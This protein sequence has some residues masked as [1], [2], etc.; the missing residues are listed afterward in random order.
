[1]FLTLCGV[2]ALLSCVRYVEYI[3]DPEK[4]IEIWVQNLSRQRSFKYLYE[5]KTQAVFTAA[6]GVC[7]IGRGEHVEG[8]WYSPDSQVP[9]EYYGFNDVE[10][11]KEQ[12]M[13]QTMSRGDE[14]DILAQVTR[15]LEFRTFEYLGID[16]TYNYTFKANI[17]F[18][19]PGRWKEMVG[20]MKVSQRSYLPTMIWAG[21]PDSSVYWRI[22]LFE[23]NRLKKIDPPIRTWKTYQVKIGHDYTKTLKKRLE[24]TDITHR[25]DRRGQDILLS[26]PYFYTIEDIREVL[27]VRP[28]RV[29]GVTQNK[30]NA[31]RLGYMLGDET[32]PLYLTEVICSEQDIKRADIRFDGASRPYIELKLKEKYT[33]TSMIAFEVDSMIVGTAVLDTLKKIDTITMNSA[34]SFYELQLLKAYI[35]QPLP[36]VELEMEGKGVE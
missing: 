26:T 2:L 11:S 15:L 25:L 36:D 31:S 30:M 16:D 3:P 18:L 19:V 12:D 8:S 5:L 20:V 14:S 24:M 9:F 7:I 35:H 10:Y 21:L 34:M 32:K 1:M 13:W 27:R 22:E 17:P 28:I 6:N 23:F 33:F 29:Y 4:D